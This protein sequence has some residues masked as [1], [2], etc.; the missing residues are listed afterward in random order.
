[1]SGPGGSDPGSGPSPAGGR[2]PSP[3]GGTEQT[4]DIVDVL[5]ADHDLILRQLRDLIGHPHERPEDRLRVN[6]RTQELIIG[7]S[8]HEAIEEQHFWPLVGDELPD[9]EALVTQ[10]LEQEQAGKWVLHH[11]HHRVPEN[12]DWDDLLL[13]AA[14]AIRRHIDFEQEMV[15][16][17]LIAHVDLADRQDAARRAVRARRLAPTRPHPGSPATPGAQ[18]S[19]GKLTGIADRLADAATGRGRRFTDDERTVTEERMS[20]DPPV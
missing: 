4:P 8:Q 20:P 18:A 15:W 7:C 13:E 6:E 2:E 19:T 1:V 9:G 12:P 16:P 10:G 3:N 5:R 17:S 11:L 14:D